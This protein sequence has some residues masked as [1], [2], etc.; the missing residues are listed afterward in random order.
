M[1]NGVTMQNFPNA[2]EPQQK[3][4]PITPLSIVLGV[5][6]VFF[7]GILV[8]VYITTKRINPVMLDQRGAQLDSQSQPGQPSP[9]PTKAQQPAPPS[10]AH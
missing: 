2:A 10:T 6:F 4:S 3:P 7:C 5:V 8:F 9:S 1:N